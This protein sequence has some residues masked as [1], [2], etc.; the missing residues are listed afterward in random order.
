MAE[1]CALFASSMNSPKG[2]IMCL[3]ANPMQE[4]ANRYMDD[5]GSVSRLIEQVKAGNSE[6]TGE[7]FGRYISKLVER[8]PA[9]LRGIR[10]G[11]QDP[12]IAAQSA[13]RSVISRIKAGK[14]R[15]L[16]DR[17]QLWRFL[18]RKLIDKTAD[19]WRRENAAIR[20]GGQIEGQSAL[21]RP[22]ESED[23]TEAFAAVLSS[24]PSPEDFACLEELVRHALDCLPDNELR[25]IAILDLEGYSAADI[26][27][28][29]KIA[30]R[31]VYDKLDLILKTWQECLRRDAY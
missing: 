8:A 23:E 3:R 11:A 30:P 13:I 14:T 6:A 19:Q 20:G 27:G 1:V 28:R 17:K 31:T 26:S 24:D 12:E 16:F 5:K 4:G 18:L 2:V 29:K 21:L 22:G 25:D 7:L 9:R 15:M 10:P